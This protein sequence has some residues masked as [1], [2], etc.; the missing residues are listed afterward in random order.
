MAL[1][2]FLAALVEDG[3]VGVAV[4]GDLALTA[5]VTAEL[6]ML[7]RLA[8]LNLAADPSD[9]S[10]AAAHW[11]ATMLYQGCLFIVRREL[12]EA[13]VLE[14]LSVPCPEPRNPGSD[15]SVDLIFRYLPDVIALARQICPGDPLLTGLL[16]LASQWPLSSVGVA[17][18]DGVIVDS[19]IEDASLRQLYADRILATGDFAR[20]NDDRVAQSIQ[21]SLGGYH[22]LC[23]ELPPSLKKEFA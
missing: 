2:P 16:Q 11:A 4:D 7:D 10:V 18:V 14:K 21:E 1:Q 17:G 9:F 19:F 23:P 15:Y 20:A 5:P 13:E 8:R 12:A 22:E 6:E 3:H